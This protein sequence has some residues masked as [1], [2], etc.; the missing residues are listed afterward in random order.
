LK[1][2]HFKQ[3]YEIKLRPE[4]SLFINPI[5]RILTGLKMTTLRLKPKRIDDY[6]VRQ[7]NYMKPCYDS[8]RH[9]WFLHIFMLERV[10]IAGLSLEQIQ[11]D[12]GLS[13]AELETVGFYYENIN[14]FFLK[15]LRKINHNSHISRHDELYLCHFE[16]ENMKKSSNTLDKFIEKKDGGRRLKW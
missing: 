15:E 12:I 9:G 10:S 6:R 5:E 11:F 7:G 4:P 2:L 16:I 3:Y 14:D 13:K 8:A 1:I